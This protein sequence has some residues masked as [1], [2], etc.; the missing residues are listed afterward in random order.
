MKLI[1]EH[2]LIASGLAFCYILLYI[3]APSGKIPINEIHIY[4]VI[5]FIGLIF[6]YIL[7]FHYYLE[8]KK[9]LELTK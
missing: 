9:E 2:R 6:I 1:N 3:I 4:M 5:I 8:D 7:N